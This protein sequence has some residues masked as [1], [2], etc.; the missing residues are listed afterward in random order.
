MA[1]LLPVNQQKKLSLRAYI[2]SIQNCL[3]LY[4]EVPMDERT[5][6]SWNSW[7]LVSRITSMSFFF[8]FKINIQCMKVRAN[9]GNAF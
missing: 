1:T 5:C 9:M 8:F 3:F 2:K 4:P 7:L 6:S